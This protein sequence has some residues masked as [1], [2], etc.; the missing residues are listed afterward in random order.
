MMIYSNSLDAMVV[1]GFM[2][3]RVVFGNFGYKV[4]KRGHYTWNDSDCV[5][6]NDNIEDSYFEEVP[7][8]GIKTLILKL[9][10]KKICSASRWL[11]KL[12]K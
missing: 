2:L 5:Y 4:L 6:Y 8:N 12:D 9:D 3:Y 11:V 7:K 1:S 10:E